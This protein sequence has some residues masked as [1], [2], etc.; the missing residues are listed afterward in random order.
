MYGLI[1]PPIYQTSILNHPVP[2][3]FLTSSATLLVLLVFFLWEARRKKLSWSNSLV[4][5][6]L[7][8][9]LAELLGK[10]FHQLAQTFLHGI[11]FDFSSLMEQPNQLG[12][13]SLTILIANIIAVTIGSWAGHE[14]KNIGKY[15]DTIFFAYVPGMMV[16]RFG[17][18]LTRYH[19]G[20]LI[21]SP[22]WRE[23]SGVER[24]EPSFYEFLSLSVLFLV[25]LR[26]RK[27]PIP[28]GGLALFVLAWVSFSRVVT[29]FFRSSDMA[30]SN[31]HLANGYTMNQVGYFLI[32]V[33][34]VYLILKNRSAT[35]LPT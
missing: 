16:T 19:S 23:L 4:I 14:T 11:N 15:L 25:I 3:V 35:K 17:S 26:L 29:D 32:F 27:N 13:V 34:A 8:Y 5:F 6:L 28:P 7:A 22:L 10:I 20:K 21:E 2:T 9:S 24:H 33:T 31:Y 18:A 1:P 30:N 12:K